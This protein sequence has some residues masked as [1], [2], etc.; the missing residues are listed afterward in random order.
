MAHPS[1]KT[2]LLIFA[3]LA[4]L[5][6]LEVALVY[7]GLGKITMVT[8]L[9]ALALTKAGLVALFFMH[10]RYETPVLRKTVLLPFCAPTFYAFVLITEGWWRKLG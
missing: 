4:M 7:T 8:G 6:V 10:L 5:T 9:V 3:W 1:R 2:Y